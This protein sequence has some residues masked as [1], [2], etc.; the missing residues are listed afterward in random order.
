[1]L[2]AE[3]GRCRRGARITYVEVDAK[4]D[5]TRDLRCSTRLYDR[6]VEEFAG[7]RLLFEHSGRAYSR[8]SVTN[9]IK[10]LAE[11]TIGKPVT[12]HMI[13]H[14]RGTLLSEQ[15]GISK[16]AS[17]LGHSSIRTTKA[18]YDHSALGEDEY[19]ESLAT[20]RSSDDTVGE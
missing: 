7:M 14:Y 17:E 10:Q 3:R 18:F 15:F 19:L 6:I 1:M 20:R 16:A 2:A 8:V 12:A 4:G 9:R 13:R 5:A 11:R